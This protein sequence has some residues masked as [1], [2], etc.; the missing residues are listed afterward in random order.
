MLTLH[1]ALSP[2]RTEPTY[3]AATYETTASGDLQADQSNGIEQKVALPAAFTPQSVP[4]ESVTHVYC[5]TMVE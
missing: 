1:S 4:K 2:L 3:T 5:V